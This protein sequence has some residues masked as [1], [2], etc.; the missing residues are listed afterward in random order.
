[1]GANAQASAANS[2][3]LGEGSVANEANTVSVGSSGND[4]RITNVAAGVNPTDAVNMSQ[5]QGV[6]DGVNSVARRAYSGVAGAVALSMI[7]DVDPGKTISVGIGTGG[8]QGYGAVAL[9]FTARISSNIKVRGGASTSSA[10]T[11]YGGGVSYQW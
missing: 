8:Y 5:L 4:R 11:A 1:L 10:G 3:A 6:Q 9:G 7:P 2:V